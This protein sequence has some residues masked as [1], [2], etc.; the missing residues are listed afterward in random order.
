[1]YKI[2]NQIL[3]SDTVNNCQ[4]NIQQNLWQSHPGWCLPSRTGTWRA[5][6]VLGAW[7]C[8]MPTTTEIRDTILS[9]RPCT[10]RPKELPKRKDRSA[11]LLSCSQAWC[12]KELLMEMP[13]LLRLA[14]RPYSL[15][16]NIHALWLLKMVPSSEIDYLPFDRM[17]FFL[18]PPGLL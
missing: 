18:L 9:L 10:S 6:R 13:Q 2:I 3:V 17:C 14:R 4:I 11:N 1:M 15:L 7:P 8:L 16:S 5:L 12:Q